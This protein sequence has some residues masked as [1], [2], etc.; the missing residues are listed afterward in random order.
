M[1]H[2]KRLLIIFYRNPE[3]GKV[4]TRLAATVGEEKALAIYLMMASHTKTIAEQ[5]TTDRV[6]YYTDFI[7]WEDNWPNEKFGKHLQHG[8]D[9]GERMSFA[10]ANGFSAGFERICIVGTDCFELTAEIIAQAFHEL[11][12]T[13]LVLHFLF[14]NKWGNKLVMPSR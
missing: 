7:D 10:F 1:K 14:L 4:K 3:L 6:I 13:V 5:V 11:A 12:Q 2:G 8:S 9:L